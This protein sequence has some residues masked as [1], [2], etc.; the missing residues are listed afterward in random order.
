M[1]AGQR[2]EAIHV[3]SIRHLKVLKNI[4]A[5]PQ[6]IADISMLDDL[7]AMGKFENNK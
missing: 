1:C 2:Y 5:R 7:E 6:D 4:S 3:V